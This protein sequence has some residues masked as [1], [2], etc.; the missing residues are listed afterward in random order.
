M[1]A[2]TRSFVVLFAARK[3]T[4]SP[5]ID[6][7]LFKFSAFDAEDREGLS[8]LVESGVIRKSDRERLVALVQDYSAAAHPIYSGL[9]LDAGGWAYPDFEKIVATAATNAKRVS[10]CFGARAGG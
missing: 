9:E 8:K 6:P 5:L 1:A 10:T 2:A 7:R 4:E 3:R